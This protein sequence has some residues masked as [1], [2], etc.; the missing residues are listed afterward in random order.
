VRPTLRG[1]VTGAWVVGVAVVLGFM[2]AAVVSVGSK[3]AQL[4]QSIDDLRN[5]RQQSSAD[6]ERLRQQ[7]VGL[8]GTPVVS[9]VPGPAGQAGQ[10]GPQGIPGRDGTDGSPGPTGSPGAAGDTGPAGPAG[11]AGVD[12]QPGADGQDGANGADGAPGPAGSPGAQGPAGPDNCTWE[13]SQ[14]DPT[15]YVCTSPS[16]QPAPTPP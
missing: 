16:P 3:N 15:T 11:P 7:V 1:V 5:D 6:I 8:G 4:A 13:P 9:A 14:T 12:G 10:I 2:I